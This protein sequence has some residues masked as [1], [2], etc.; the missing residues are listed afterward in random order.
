MRVWFQIFKTFVFAF[1]DEKYGFKC[2]ISDPPSKPIFVVDNRILNDSLRI[3][4]G[5]NLSVCC[6]SDSYPYPTYIWNSAN[7]EYT[8]QCLD[9][10]KITGNETIQCTT[11]NNMKLPN[12]TIISGS[13]SAKLKI[14]AM[15]KWFLVL[16]K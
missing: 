5:N 4:P 14:H 2:K 8:S 15:C 12:N 11:T 9:F 10:S 16:R 7:S 3:I 13:N 6:K 1:I